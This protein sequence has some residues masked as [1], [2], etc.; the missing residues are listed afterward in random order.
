MENTTVNHIR[1]T[2]P[3]KGM[4]CASC[5]SS[6]ESML[7]AQKGVTEANVNFASNSVLIDYNPDLVSMEALQKSISDIGFELV[8]AAPSSENLRKEKAERYKTLKLKV[9]GAALLSLPVFII[10]MFHIHVPFQNWILLALSLPVVLWSGKHFYVNAWKKIRHGQTNMDTLIALGTGVAFVYSLFNTL[11]PDFLVQ[12]GIEPHVY[13]ESAVVIITLVLFGNLMEERAKEKTSTAIEKLIGLQPKQATLLKNGQ[14]VVVPVEEVQVDDTLL[15]RPGEKIPVDGLVIEGSSYVD[16]SMVTGEPEPAAKKQND[17]AIGGTINKNGSFVMKA[18]KIGADTMLSRII[19]MVED[20]QGSKAPVQKLADKISSIFVPVVVG[21]AL[22]SF[23]AWYFLG[24]EPAFT[25]ALVILVT[26]LIIACPCALGLA[27]PTAITVG[28]GK[29]ALHGILI[30]N[31]ESLE[32]AREINVLMVDKTGTITK[33]KPELTGFRHSGKIEGH[34]FKSLLVSIES[35]SEHPL[36]EAIVNSLK[37][38]PETKMLD[39]SGFENYPGQGVG[40]I[41]NNQLYRIGS[42]RLLK[43]EAL[44]PDQEIMNVVESWEQD[45]QTVVVVLR[46]Q[47]LIGAAAVR[48]TVKKNAA[49]AIKNLHNMN[50]E[51]VM[52]TGDNRYN[53]EKVAAEAG[54]DRV[55]AEALPEDKAAWVKKYQDQ[56]KIVGMAGD[57]INDAPALALADVGIAMGTGT[58]VA[59]ESAAITLVK[60]D[61]SKIAEAIRLSRETVKTIRQNLFWAFIYNVISLPVAAGILYPVNGFLLNPMIAG[62]AMAFSS[63]SVVMNSLRLKMKKI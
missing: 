47:E 3:V 37:E 12:F 28:I 45:G 51:V 18:E 9:A 24:P 31:A 8:A 54:I 30:R 35:H 34:L 57:G 40:A 29:G 1:K 55:I 19:M 22:I 38:D 33:G 23:G 48:D 11:F 2:Y 5:A 52:L 21:I 62:G 25:N 44:L 27:T 36:A 46:E 14:Q 59:M 16:E 58:D 6:V 13:Y 4:S 43:D 63:V 39:M 26:V 49:Q 7:R 41:Y 20:A 32:K 61:I 17:R 10:S 42:V 53:A 50:I 15:I 60:G 56:G